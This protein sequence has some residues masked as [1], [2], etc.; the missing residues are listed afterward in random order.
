VSLLMR[1]ILRSSYLLKDVLDV[2][3]LRALHMDQSPISRAPGIV[4]LWSVYFLQTIC[5]VYT[6]SLWLWHRCRRAVNSR[7]FHA[8]YL[9]PPL[10]F[11]V[12]LEIR[13]CNKSVDDVMTS[14]RWRNAFPIFTPE[15]AAVLGKSVIYL[16]S[17]IFTF[18]R[19]HLSEMN[20]ICFVCQQYAGYSG[21]TAATAHF[22]QM[23]SKL[24]NVIETRTVENRI[25]EQESIGPL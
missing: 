3:W 19:R 1:D 15:I 22:V 8:R 4:M 5:F 24:S 13:L 12:N 25:N 23:T 9:P 2:S 6:R 16:K 17:R 21:C 10:F 14:S 18:F 11:T 20:H 7:T